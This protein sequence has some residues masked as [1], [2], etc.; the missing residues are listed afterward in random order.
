MIRLRSKEGV[1]EAAPQKFVEVTDLDGN[2][3]VLVYA[4]NQGTVH[5]VHADDPEAD[6]Y[7]KLFDVKF[8]P[9]IRHKP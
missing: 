6:K 4:D 7:Q 2:I 8:C 9:I 3:A 5:L 1:V